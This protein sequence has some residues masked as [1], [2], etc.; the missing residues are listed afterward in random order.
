MDRDCSLA[1]IVQLAITLAYR[2]TGAHR[3]LLFRRNHVIDQTTEKGTC[4]PAELVEPREQT[5]SQ[6]QQGQRD[7]NVL[8]V[9]RLSDER[10]RVQQRK[11]ANRESTHYG[12]R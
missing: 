1:L 8:R 4:K 12:N 7:W 6:G 9:E 11:L 5:G 10:E 3:S 2:L